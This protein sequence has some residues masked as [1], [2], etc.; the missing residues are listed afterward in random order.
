MTEETTSAPLTLDNLRPG[1]AVTGKVTTLVMAGAMVDIGLEKDALLHLSQFESQDFREPSDVYSEGDAIDSFV[2]K[3]DSDNARVALTMVKPPDVPWEDI[4]NGRTYTGK[5]TRIENFGAFVDIGAER[6]GMVHVSEM[7]DGYVSSP[8]DVV[9]IGDEV[10]VR[11]I[12][13]NRKRKQIDL[14]MKTP[15]EEIEEIM[16][17]DEDIPSA[18]E[19]AFR[20][21]Q[22]AAGDEGR[23][24]S[25]KKRNKNRRRHD[26]DIYRRTLRD[27]DHDS[28]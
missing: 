15:I 13:L 1:T 9:S 24:P 26:D 6:P 4:R 20:R 11:V 23:G 3:V 16:E 21:A 18:M 12:K 19:I 10:E 7:A 28:Y 5:V 8:N 22:E 2:L 17:P 27:H 25:R 14:S